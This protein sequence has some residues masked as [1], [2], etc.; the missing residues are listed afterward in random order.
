M[1]RVSE[2]STHKGSLHSEGPSAGTY[3]QHWGQGRRPQRVTQKHRQAGGGCHQRKEQMPLTSWNPSLIK[4]KNLKSLRRGSKLPSLEPLC[5]EQ[6]QNISSR[7]KKEKHLKSRILYHSKQRWATH[8]GGMRTLRRFHIQELTLPDLKTYNN[9]I[10][11]QTV[12]Y[13][14]KER[15]KG[16]WNR[17]QKQTHTKTVH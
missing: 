13:Q 15:H 3:K 11:I 5:E 8:G 10:I 7:G 17:V 2:N 1:F 4:S 6:K 16:Q 9:V 12:W 14:C